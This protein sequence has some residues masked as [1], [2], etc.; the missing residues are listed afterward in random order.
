MLEPAR[1]MGTQRRKLR[2]LLGVGLTV[3]LVTSLS[4]CLVDHL[5]EARLVIR[6]DGDGIEIAFCERT[7]LDELWVDQWVKERSAVWSATPRI[8]VDA[9]EIL[10]KEDLAPS[11]TELGRFDFEDASEISVTTL[12][13][14]DTTRQADFSLDGGL[15]SE[16]WLHPDGTRT[17]EPCSGE[18]ESP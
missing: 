14:G 17:T 1:A 2:R 18:T 12:A 5:P 6:R 10:G 13:E 9:G 16:T 3:A 15:S 11:S 7:K 8:L 4:G